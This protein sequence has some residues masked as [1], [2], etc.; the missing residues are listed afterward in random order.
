[1]S[2]PVAKYAVHVAIDAA[3]VPDTQPASAVAGDPF[4]TLSTLLKS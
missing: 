4:T 2:G 3:I 1:M